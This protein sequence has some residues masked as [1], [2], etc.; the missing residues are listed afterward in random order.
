MTAASISTCLWF[1]H[2]AEA[3]ATLYCSLIPGS[4]I[5]NIFRQQGDP[6]RRAFIVEFHLAGQSYTAMNGGP[7]YTLTPA[8]SVVVHVDTQSEVDHLWASLLAGGGLEN[9]CGWLT[10]RFGLSW[11]IIPRALPRL[12]QS[13]TSGRVMRAMMGMVRIDIAALEAAAAG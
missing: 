1:D 3:A 5:T 2:H 7:H 6:D 12:L 10:D 13:D 4:A 11:Q 8:A 9:R